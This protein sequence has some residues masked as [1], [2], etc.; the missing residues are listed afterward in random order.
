M[1]LA[2]GSGSW[3]ITRTS[4]GETICELFDSRTVAK[5]NTDAYRV[6]TAREYLERLNRENNSVS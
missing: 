1:I 5:I 2:D 4:S 3:I 6:E